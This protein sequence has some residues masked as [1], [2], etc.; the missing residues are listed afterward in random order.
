MPR[1]VSSIVRQTRRKIANFLWPQEGQRTSTTGVASAEFL[2]RWAVALKEPTTDRLSVYDDMDEMDA[3]LV[4]VAAALD[5]LADNAVHAE[6]G[7]EETFTIVYEDSA[8]VSPEVEAAI[9]GVL[10]RTRLREKMYSF[11]RELLKYG[12]LFL[13]R[14]VGTDGLVYRLMYLPPRTMVR[15][16]DE[17]G[18]LLSGNTPGNSAFDQVDPTTGEVIASFYAWQI[19]H[20][21][22]N[23]SGSDKYGRPLMYAARSSWRKLQ[24][25]EEAL[26]M[27]WLTRA[28]A[29]LLF[30]LDVTGKTDAEAEQYIRRF[31]ESLQQRRIG[32][33]V[34]YGDVLSVVKDVFV[35]QRYLELGNNVVK[36]LSDVKV[37][38]TSNTGFTNLQSV[39]YYQQKILTE[40][41]VPKAHLGL[42]RDINA[43]A[44]LQLQDKRY[45]KTIRRIQRVLS[46]IIE[47][48]IDFQLVLLGI[49]PT[50]VSYRVQWPVPSWA[51]EVDIGQYLRDVSL[52]AKELV[53][54][55][56]IDSEYIATELLHMT[57]QQW[58]AVSARTSVDGNTQ[59]DGNTPGD[60]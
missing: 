38:D 33:G 12:D 24:A 11:A 23:R 60:E 28:F 10:D 32:A 50:T 7:E 8:S 39:E 58:Q 13:E 51:D 35:G 25:M 36:S 34:Q 41:R 29:R 57:P 48:T 49:D 45:T 42:E 21:R 53:A 22:W 59:G 9:Q 6:R 19:E 18:V 47:H 46:E 14:V 1:S 31:K 56:V 4:E 2:E 55:G 3:S 20:A 40:T 26:V 43:K 37:L 52:A 16:E 54:L 27:N 44:T 30:E 5:H 17:H 15:N